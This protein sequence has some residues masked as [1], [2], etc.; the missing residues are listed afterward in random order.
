LTRDGGRPATPGK[1]RLLMGGGEYDDAAR[2]QGEGKER[3]GPERRM[4]RG[5]EA[6][7]GERL[8]KLGQHPPLWKNASSALIG[9]RRELPSVIGRGGSSRFPE[10]I[11]TPPTGRRK[12][13]SGGVQHETRERVDAE[14]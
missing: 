10:E 1:L 2:P 8:E 3:E 13:G 12:C 14:G 9:G 5:R 4:T 7:P 11:R 6:P